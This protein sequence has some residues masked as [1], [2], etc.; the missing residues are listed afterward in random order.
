MKCYQRENQ[1]FQILDKIVKDPETFWI[2]RFRDV[3]KG[4]NFS[5]LMRLFSIERPNYNCSELPQKICAR[6]LVVSPALDV[7]PYSSGATCYRPP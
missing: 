7:H 3:D 6:Y 1:C 2:L 4:T 5:G